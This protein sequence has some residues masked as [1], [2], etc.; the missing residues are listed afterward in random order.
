M[1]CPRPCPPRGRRSALRRRA[2]GNVAPASHGQHVPTPTAASAWCVNAALS[3][4]AWWP[5]PLSFWP[6]KCWPSHVWRG[7]TLLVFLGLSV[8]DLCPTYATDRRQTASSLNKRYH[9]HSRP[10]ESFQTW[11]DCKLKPWLQLRFDFIR[12]QFDDL[13]YD[14][15]GCCTET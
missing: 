6:W 7:L 5:W 1:I 3:K 4:A 2:D 10:A 15:V 14:H 8:L 11:R 9:S 13:R 12:V